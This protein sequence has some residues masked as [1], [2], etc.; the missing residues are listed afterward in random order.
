MYCDSLLYYND[1]IMALD[2]GKEIIAY[3]EKFDNER[4]TTEKQRLEL[5]KANIMNWW[6]FTIVVTILFSALTH[7]IHKPTF[8]P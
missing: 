7:I 6:M 8:A 1:S 5:E 3:K 4:L 2:K